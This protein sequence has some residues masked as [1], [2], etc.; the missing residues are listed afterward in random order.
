M[1]ICRDEGVLFFSYHTFSG[2]GVLWWD[3]MLGASWTHVGS[4]G[5]LALLDGRKRL[6]NLY[7]IA[8]PLYNHSAS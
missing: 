1:G 8:R 2:G 5:I 6:C 3:V 4:A 7:L